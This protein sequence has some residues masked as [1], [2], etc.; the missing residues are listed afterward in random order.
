[1]VLLPT[2]DET[3]REGLD[4]LDDAVASVAYAI[5]TRLTGS[6]QEAAWSARRC[7]EYFDHVANENFAD[8][9]VD[10]PT[11]ERLL[12]DPKI[13]DELKRQHDL[14]EVLQRSETANNPSRVLDEA[15]VG[16]E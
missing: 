5:R 9:G 8:V 13:Q 15:V 6:S 14:M 16:D 1:M 3:T 11:E 12:A 7:Y 4:L 10:E 2:E